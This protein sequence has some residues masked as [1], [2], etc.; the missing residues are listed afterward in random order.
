VTTYLN[1]SKIDDLCNEIG[2][3]NLPVL[4]D[5]FLGEL[6]EYQTTLLENSDELERQIGEISHALKSSAASFGAD[7]LCYTAKSID[8]RVKAG[9][10][11]S[12]PETR[13]SMLESIRATIDAFGSILK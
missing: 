8:A 7:N 9:Q 3:E 2:Q 4:L 10:V 13:E 11:V 5:I 6:N 12:T 1:S